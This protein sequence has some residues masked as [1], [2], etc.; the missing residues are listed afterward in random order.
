MINKKSIN[1]ESIDV[2]HETTVITPYTAKTPPNNYREIFIPEMLGFMIEKGNIEL[3]QI[4]L[5]KYFN[6]R[7]GF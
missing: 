4:K 2:G 5:I 7:E 3:N 6:F 1:Y